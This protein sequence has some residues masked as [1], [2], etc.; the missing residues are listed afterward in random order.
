MMQTMYSPPGTIDE[1]S[2]PTHLVEEDDNITAFS[3]EYDLGERA[4][5]PGQGILLIFF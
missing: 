5:P 3:D 4:T 1:G 2:I